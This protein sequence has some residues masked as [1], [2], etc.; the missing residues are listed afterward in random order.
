[1]AV[2]SSRGKEFMKKLILFLALLTVVHSEFGSQSE[3]KLRT[4]CSRFLN[5]FKKTMLPSPFALI[6]ETPPKKPSIHTP[7][8]AAAQEEIGIRDILPVYDYDKEDELYVGDAVAYATSDKMSVNRSSFDRMPYGAQRTIALHEAFHHKYHDVHN[9]A[10]LGHLLAGTALAAP[11][12]IAQLWRKASRIRSRP[13]RIACYATP[14]I[15]YMATVISCFGIV[16]KANKLACEAEFRADLSAIKHVKC[17]ECAKEYRSEIGY[18]RYPYMSKS[19]ITP[20]VNVFKQNNQLC[21][22]HKKPQ[23]FT[24]LK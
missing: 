16:F 19:D 20:F 15:T 23:G 18:S 17:Y 11:S 9:H 8:F 13:L 14:I 4:R 5:Y 22:Y 10:Q 1:M 24:P 12:L 2:L 21:T 7:L 6:V 3:S